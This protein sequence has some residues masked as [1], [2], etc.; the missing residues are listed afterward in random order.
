MALSGGGQAMTE[1]SYIEKYGK[2]HVR[3]LCQG[4]WIEHSVRKTRKMDE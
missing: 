4:Q 1:M 3:L 2:V